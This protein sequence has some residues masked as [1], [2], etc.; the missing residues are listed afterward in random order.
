MQIAIFTL[1]L[2]FPLSAAAQTY[3]C[4]GEAGAAVEHGGPRG[5]AA[6]V[7]DASKEKYIVSNANGTWQFRSLGENRSP[8]TCDSESYCEV[9]GGFSAYFFKDNEN[10]FT[11]VSAV[12]FKP[13]FKR[14]M[15]ITISGKCSAL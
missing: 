4:V 6:G 7:Y 13:D 9:K 14:T 10:V 8:L 11:Y 5:I 2:L 3:L 1:S 15:V 12:G